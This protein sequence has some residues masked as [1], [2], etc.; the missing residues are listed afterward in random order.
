MHAADTG[1]TFGNGSPFG[2]FG[3]HEPAAHHAVARQSPSTVHIVP[4]EPVVRLQMV[5]ARPAQSA[6]EPRA[7]TL[8][9]FV[10]I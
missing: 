6:F 4:H 2:D 9:W 5:P 1:G 7:D 3:V 10:R 8:A